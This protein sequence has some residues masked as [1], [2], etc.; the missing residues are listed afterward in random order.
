MKPGPPFELVDLSFAMP[1]VGGVIASANGV[2]KVVLSTP[3]N[4]FLA[5]QFFGTIRVKAVHI[6]AIRL[7]PYQQLRQRIKHHRRGSR[8]DRFD[9]GHMLEFQG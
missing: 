6:D 2:A 5:D 8:F 3:N 1:I 7:H 9:H 4:G